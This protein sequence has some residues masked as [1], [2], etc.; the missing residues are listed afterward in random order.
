MGGLSTGGMGRDIFQ[1]L[2]LSIGAGLFEEIIFRVFLLNLLFFI[3]NYFIN[4]KLII[5]SLSVL[6][7][8]LLFSI[9]H[10]VGSMAD[11]WE[12]YSFMFRWIAGIL[13]TVL[14]FAR[15]FAITSYTHALYDIWVLV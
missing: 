1:N 10:Y 13:F 3:F 12:L 9:S 8:S 4:K 2:A 15:G 7:S 14:Y 11:S 6:I 5:V